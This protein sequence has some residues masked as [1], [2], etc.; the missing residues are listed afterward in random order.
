MEAV[1]ERCWISPSLAPQASPVDGVGLFAVEPIGAGQVIIRLGGRVI[2]EAALRAQPEPYSSVALGDGR[3]L[4]ID[5]DHPS[6]KGNHG[7][8]GNL[9]CDDVLTVSARR[10]IVVGEE[11]LIDYVLLTG[12]DDWSMICACGSRL[13]RGRLRGTDWRRPELQ[14]RYAGHFSPPIQAKIDAFNRPPR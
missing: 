12:V 4:L 13:C 14:H 1:P 6:A 7:C 3:H 11:A 8:D 10:P 9:W 2:D 5:N